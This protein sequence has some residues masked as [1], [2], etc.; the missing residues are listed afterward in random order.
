MDANTPKKALP[1]QYIQ[2]LLNVATPDDIFAARRTVYRQ[3]AASLSE[4]AGAQCIASS[5]RVHNKYADILGFVECYSNTG[6]WTVAA[7]D[8]MYCKG[9]ESIA[10]CT[11][12]SGATEYAG[13]VRN[14]ADYVRILDEGLSVMQRRFSVRGKPAGVIAVDWKVLWGAKDGFQEYFEGRITELESVLNKIAATFNR[15]L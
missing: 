13:D 15:K 4:E 1:D 5:I 2:T 7:K 14:R 11:M 9:A 3:F 8:T 12:R 6:A 10:W